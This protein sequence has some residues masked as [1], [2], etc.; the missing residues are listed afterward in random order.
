MVLSLSNVWYNLFLYRT[1]WKR[2][3]S[4]KTNKM[5]RND[6]KRCR[7]N[8]IDEEERACF[9]I[10]QVLITRGAESYTSWPSLYDNI[11]LRWL[12]FSH[13]H[14]LN[15]IWYAWNLR[16]LYIHCTQNMSVLSSC[17]GLIS[18]CVEESH[19]FVWRWLLDGR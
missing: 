12:C 19:S 6:S 17:I 5:I 15:I 9:L 1:Y 11:H 2:K 4:E 14:D 13:L 10:T 8:L 3:E 7:I 16:L 18:A